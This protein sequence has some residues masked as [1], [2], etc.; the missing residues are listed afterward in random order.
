MD[1]ICMIG[2]GYVGLP[3]ATMFATKGYDVIGYDINK[4]VIDA[5][6]AGNII[7]EEEGLSELVKDAVL[8][9]KLKGATSCPKDCNIY[10]IAVP[11][12]I[13]EDKTANM[14]YVEEATKA[15]VPC[16]KKDDLVIL[17]S[18]SPPKTTT[19]LIV[20]LL[21]QTGLKVGEEVFVA[22]SPERILPGQIIKELKTN[23]R[24]VGGINEKS[25]IKAK[26]LYESI[27][28]AEIFITDATTA[29]LCKVMENTFR[30]VN[31]AL[32]N[33]LAKISEQLG[34]N[35]FEVIKLA[36]MHPRVNL[37]SPGPGVG[38]HCIALDPWFLVEKSSDAKLIKKARL[39]NDSMPEFVFQKI[40]KILGTFKGQTISIYG[41][42]YKANVD[43][44]RESPII[45][46][47]NMLSKEDLNIKICEP[48]VKKIE[49]NFDIYDA[50]KDS[51]LFIL[52]VNHKEFLDLDFAKI[53]SLMKEKNVLDT[54]N[55]LDKNKIKANGI[56]YY[57]L[58]DC[59]EKSVDYS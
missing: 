29:E 37:L 4:D 50:V 12:P 17:E 20:P 43:D 14:T 51:S 55:F 8:K 57:L 52:A 36:N 33:E 16:L 13:N 31:I 22:H 39:I 47:L 45:T 35:A 24:I 1:K 41:L 40:K 23:S 54:R 59:S 25:S 6:N 44:I 56:N 15:I 48:H 3:A 32:A 19:D 27:V 58:G 2:L 53:S 7:I 9:G 26:K 49:N 34:V 11:T 28:E 30:D 42:T 38:G 18:T 21:K 10:I 5:L 46:L